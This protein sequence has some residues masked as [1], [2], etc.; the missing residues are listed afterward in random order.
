MKKILVAVDIARSG[1][2]DKVIN[3][4]K[5]IAG[6]MDGEIYLMHAVEPLPGR[7]L[8]EIPESVIGQQKAYAEEKMAELKETH[9]IANGVLLDGPAPRMILEYAEEIG[10]D[11]IVLHSPAP[12]FS[13]YFLGSC[14]GRVVRHAHCSVH[15]V[16]EAKGGR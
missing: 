3:T 8:P 1:G 10:A 12:D 7:V 13:D 11:L 15:I 4:A 6:A 14:A 5:A 2:N 9:G 16:R